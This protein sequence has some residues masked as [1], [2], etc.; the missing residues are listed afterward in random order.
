LHVGQRDIGDGRVEHLHQHREHDADS[1]D[2]PPSAIQR[3]RDR[4]CA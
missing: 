1:D 2:Q 3:M 4:A